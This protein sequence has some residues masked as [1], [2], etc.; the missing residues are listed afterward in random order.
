[1]LWLKIITIKNVFKTY[2]TVSGTECVKLTG[3]ILFLP[4]LIFL[5]ALIK[6]KLLYLI[7]SEK[8]ERIRGFFNTL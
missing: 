1:M 5:W 2:P 8:D 6:C 3:K 4:N 7:L